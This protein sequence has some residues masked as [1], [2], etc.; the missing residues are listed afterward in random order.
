MGA[1]VWYEQSDQRPTS[2]IFM[3][4][5]VWASYGQHSS[6]ST[7]AHY[8]TC[9][10][11]CT[12]ACTALTVLTARLEG[13]VEDAHAML[14]HVVD[15]PVLPL[16]VLA[17]VESPHLTYDDRMAAGAQIGEP[18]FPNRRHVRRERAVL[19]VWLHEDRGPIC[20]R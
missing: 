12:C 3:G 13:K 18:R 5:L 9:T 8:G 6:S 11:T 20:M 19:E 15:R 7:H 16:T 14:G 17:S 10:R 1:L 2:W 4:V